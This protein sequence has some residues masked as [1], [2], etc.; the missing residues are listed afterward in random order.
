M[1]LTVLVLLLLLLFESPRASN[2]AMVLKLERPFL[3][4]RGERKEMRS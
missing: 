2:S 4:G 3:S 1:G